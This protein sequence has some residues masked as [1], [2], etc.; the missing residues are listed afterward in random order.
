MI[1]LELA[2]ARMSMGIM[3]NFMY[4]HDQWIVKMFIINS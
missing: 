2:A 1:C 4:P 3:V